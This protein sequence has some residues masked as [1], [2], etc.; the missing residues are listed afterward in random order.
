MKLIKTRDTITSKVEEERVR[1]ITQVVTD[2]LKHEDTY[3][4]DTLLPRYVIP[5]RLGDGKMAYMITLENAPALNPE[6]PVVLAMFDIQ[7]LQNEL[8]KIGITF[9][10][11]MLRRDSGAHG[12]R[13]PKLVIALG[14]KS[15]D[16][17][18]GRH[19]ELD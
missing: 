17:F 7:E 1:A 2:V 5:R 12:D 16:R 15:E 18:A 13:T 11:V 3:P 19:H 14:E 9:E 10:T 6:Y 4:E 8:D